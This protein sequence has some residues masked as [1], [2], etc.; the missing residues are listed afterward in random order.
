MGYVD[1][2]GY[3]PGQVATW[4]NGDGRL[5]YTPNQDVN[6]D[7][8]PYLEGPVNS[9][10]WEMLREGIEDYEY[11]KL[12]ESGIAKAKRAG[13]SAALI[14]QA[15]KLLVVPESIT[16]DLTHYTKDPQ[17]LLARRSQIAEMI[18]KLSGK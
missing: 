17:L 16:T 9:I 18:E 3:Q 4:G 11:F 2:Y 8:K 15:E 12:L 10:R 14:A 7:K 6:R 5:L 13:K 1:G